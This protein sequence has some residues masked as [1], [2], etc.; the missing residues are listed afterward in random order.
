MTDSSKRQQFLSKVEDMANKHLYMSAS[1]LS[2]T[3][4]IG[5]APN[6]FKT[7]PDLIYVPQFR[8][9]G[10]FDE[11]DSVLGH[12]EIQDE[13]DYYYTIDNFKASL[14]KSYEHEVEARK[15]YQESLRKSDQDAI[16][17]LI[18]GIED[19][20]LKLPSPFRKGTSKKQYKKSSRK[21]VSNTVPNDVQIDDS[22]VPNVEDVKDVEEQIEVQNDD[23]E[24]HQ[25]EVQHDVTNDQ[26]AVQ[27]DVADQHIVDDPRL[28]RAKSP[29]NNPKDKR[30][31]LTNRSRL[32]PI[33]TTVSEPRDNEESTSSSRTRLRP[34]VVE[35]DSTPIREE[36]SSISRRRLKPIDS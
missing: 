24:E 22:T 23:V 30:T 28:T 21:T 12:Y 8:L 7:N 25:V 26:I 16:L 2:N 5:G 13:L 9:V 33:T 15:Q 6:K 34:I 11:V 4:T 31:R 20:R 14:R 19:C 35:E 18:K 17:D 3:L 36:S 27:Q 29:K 1:K 10:T 32:Q